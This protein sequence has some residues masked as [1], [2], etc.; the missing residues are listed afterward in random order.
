MSLIIVPGCF[1]GCA[2]SL[3]SYFSHSHL[4]CEPASCS[5]CTAHTWS[6]LQRTIDRRDRFICIV[7]YCPTKTLA[8]QENKY[9]ILVLRNT[10]AIKD[11]PVTAMT[12]TYPVDVHFECKF[13]AALL[14]LD[15]LSL[16]LYCM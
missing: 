1:R 4:D 5:L 13:F 3:A 11:K 12:W 6:K 14:A 10:A 8:R 7:W 9:V 2:K 16:M 15:N